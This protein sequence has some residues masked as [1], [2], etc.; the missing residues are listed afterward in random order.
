MKSCNFYQKFKIRYD[1]V[2]PLLNLQ[3]QP[4]T[5]LNLKMY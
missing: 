2:V 1:F 4:L 3:I 5:E